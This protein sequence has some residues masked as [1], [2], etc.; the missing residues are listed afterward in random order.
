MSWTWLKHYLPRSLYARAALILI[1]P[2]ITLQLVVSVTFIRRDLE[3]VTTQMT[4]TIVRELQLIADQTGSTT[5]TEALNTRM[6]PFLDTLRLKMRFVNPGEVPQR[7]LIRWY[8]YSARIV[9]DTL[10]TAIPETLAVGFPDNR[11]VLLYLQTA[12]GPAEVVIGRRRVTAAAPHQLIASTLGFGLL[13]TTI[14]FL[15]LRNQLRPITRLANAAQAFGRGRTL[16]YWPS[17]A[18]EVRAAGSAFLD[19][20]GRIERHIE[21]RTL[22]LSG[23]SHDLRTPL[24]RLRLGLSML[25][26]DDAAPLLRDVD[27][28]QRLVDT[29]L[30]FARGASEGDPEPVDPQALVAAI[31]ADAQRAGRAVELVETEGAGEMMLRPLAIR[32]AIENLLENAVR[33]GNRAEVSV[34]LTDRALRIRIEDDGPGIAPDMRGEAVKPFTRLDPSRNQNRGGGVGL[35]LAIAMDITRAHGGTLRLGESDRLGGLLADIV[36]GR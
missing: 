7:D 29:F 8:D 11:D 33:Y 23:V 2:V 14:A 22:M 9:R 35:G 13:M 25:D 16:P 1:L 6:A 31:V 3:D 4:M 30:D 12:L 27:E 21:Q 36:I 18:T 28:M 32:R 20:R 34:T 15:Y 24:T 26:E 17:G 5:D 19:M 10:R